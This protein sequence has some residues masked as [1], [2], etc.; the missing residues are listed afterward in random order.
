LRNAVTALVSAAAVIA[1]VGAAHHGT[2]PVWR[3]P[4]VPAPRALD[5]RA[6]AT[7]AGAPMPAII[8]RPS[9]K[10]AGPRGAW[11]SIVYGSDG[12]G[13]VEPCG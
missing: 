4:A 10:P 13:E 8:P 6:A 1:A 11:L 2:P 5:A 12:Q 9:S 7:P 3:P